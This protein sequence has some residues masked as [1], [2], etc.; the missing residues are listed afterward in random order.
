MK[1]WNELDKTT[2]KQ[3]LENQQQ[4]LGFKKPEIF[5]QRGVFGGF[6]ISSSKEGKDF[7]IKKLQ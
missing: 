3:M 4:Q 6:N 1:N 7:W 5:I 2:K